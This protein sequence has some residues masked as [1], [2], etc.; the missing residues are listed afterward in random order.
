MLKRLVKRLARFWKST[1]MLYRV[2]QL[3]RFSLILG[4]VAGLVL[5]L[6]EQA[7]DVLR[8]LGEELGVQAA[9]RIV[10]FALAAIVSAV[11]VWWTA[12]V[13]FYFRFR[14]PASSPKVFPRVKEH[15]PRLLGSLVLLLIAAASLKASL[16]YSTRTSGAGLRL[17]LLSTSFALLAV[18]FYYFMKKRR[19]WFG[20]KTARPSNLRSLRE[21]PRLAW[22]PLAATAALGFGLM[23]LFAYRAV[24]LGPRLGTAAVA[25]IAIIGLLPVA[26]LLVYLGNRRN[27]PIVSIVLLWAV[28][29]TYVA[30]NHYVRLAATSTSYDVPPRKPPSAPDANASIEGYLDRWREGLSAGPDGTVPLFL[31]AAEG[32]GVRAAYWTALVLGE[33]EDRARDQQL[34]FGR[35][36]FAISGVSGGSLG[37]AVYAS[38][39]RERSTPGARP[40]DVQCASPDRL[41]ERAER[42]LSRDFLS[43]T[44]AVMLFP[45]LLQQLVPI[46]LLNDRAVAIERAW[47]AA[48]DECEDGRLFS[49]KFVAAWAGTQS[50]P[51]L[52][53]NSTVVETGQRLI[54][55]PVS[56]AEPAFSDALDG[57]RVLGPELTL[58]TAVHTSARFTYV[59]PAGT[60]RRQDEWTHVGDADESEWIRL[61]DG[62][63]F[64]NSGAVT[65]AEILR[66]VQRYAARLPADAPRIRPI[67]LHVSNDPAT[68]DPRDLLEPRKVL[69]QLVAPLK[70][71]LNVRTARGFQAREDLAQRA[72]EESAAAQGGA[73][74]VPL[75]LHLHFR[76]CSRPNQSTMAQRQPL[77]LGWALSSLARQEMRRQL[78]I[79]EA[80]AGVAPAPRDPDPRKAAEADA[81]VINAKPEVVERARDIV[82]RNRVNTEAVLALLGGSPPPLH[83][84]ENT[85][86]C[87]SLTP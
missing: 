64:E 46:G 52:F 20:V 9:L 44:V 8:T 62:G 41:R 82:E 84:D 47:E 35:H 34:D 79:G 70:A 7:Q 29:C 26:T 5:L 75:R 18:A 31:V 33:I 42:I 12:R 16:S 45:D 83:A 61:V 43:P 24:T 40:P 32:G 50:I 77:P 59:S 10:W 57:R 68:N 30:D 22:V 6:D 27:L 86:G 71:L 51:L 80:P 48:W 4:V 65:A 78:G 19:D 14:N 38:L 63:Y 37:A 54:T 25:L 2:L 13:M 36:V 21:L 28:F 66:G 69:N 17:A 58:S 1:R 81:G 23:I 56:I 53:L 74:P 85:W 76:L 60:V 55:A 49:E 15:L 72:V 3:V 11:L 87:P 39:L 67:V 73:T